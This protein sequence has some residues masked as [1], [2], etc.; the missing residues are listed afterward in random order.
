MKK[1]LDYLI[2]GVIYS[3][4]LFIIGAAGLGFVYIATNYLI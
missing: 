2:L 3:T 4:I 1:L